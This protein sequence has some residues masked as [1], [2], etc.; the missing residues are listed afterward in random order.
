MT[1]RTASAS[2]DRLSKRSKPDTLAGK[3]YRQ[4]TMN[5]IELVAHLNKTLVGQEGVAT[6]EFEENSNPTLHNL[7]TFEEMEMPDNN[8]F[9]RFS[10]KTVAIFT[11]LLM[12]SI[13]KER[14][15]NSWTAEDICSELYIGGKSF[16]QIVREA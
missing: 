3:R 11:P 14:K 6:T 15:G 10:K 8:V 16:G 4:D 5:N 7:G 9:I 12:I 13:V 1:K 2:G